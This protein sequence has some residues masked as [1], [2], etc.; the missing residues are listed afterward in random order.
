MKDLFGIDLET[1]LTCEESDETAVEA[2]TVYT[3]KCNISQD[4]NHLH[5]GFKIGLCEDREKRSEKLG[6]VVILLSPLKS[7]SLPKY[8]SVQLVRKLP[9]QR[10]TRA[11]SLSLSLCVWLAD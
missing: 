3:F 8:L 2:S 4:V 7:A 10:R 5:D 1:S 6:R 9:Q 11:L